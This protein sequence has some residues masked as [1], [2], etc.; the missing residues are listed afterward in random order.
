MRYLT[1]KQTLEFYEVPQLFLAVDA[2]NA[3]YLCLLYNQEDGYEYVA[4]QVSELRLQDFFAGR[5]DL[6]RAYTEPEQDNLVYHVRVAEKQIMADRLLQPEDIT[7]AML[8]DAGYYYDAEDAVEDS[9]T[10]TM[11]VDI[12]AADRG[13]FADIVRRMGWATSLIKKASHKVAVL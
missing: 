7:E 5:F 9:A 8:P 12:P 1:L 4:V 11:Q 2:M 10:D 3:N 6:R 13:L